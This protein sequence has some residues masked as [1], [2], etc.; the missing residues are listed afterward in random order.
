MSLPRPFRATILVSVVALDLITKTYEEC[1]RQASV[2]RWPVQVNHCLVTLGADT[3]TQQTTI[4]LSSQPQSS[5]R[6]VLRAS[7]LIATNIV[8]TT[9]RIELAITNMVELSRTGALQTFIETFC[10]AV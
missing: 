6:R 7:A 1:R 5:K 10:P 4:K 9:E 2:V 3:L 8:A